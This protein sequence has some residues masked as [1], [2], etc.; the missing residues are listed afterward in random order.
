VQRAFLAEQAAQCGYCTA[1]LVMASV[2]LLRA[3]RDPTDA[4]IREALDGNLC[5]CGSQ[6]RVIRAVKRAAREARS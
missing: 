3:E 1:G 2:A 4:R 5:R 6:A